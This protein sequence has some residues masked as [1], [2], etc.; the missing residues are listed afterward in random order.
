MTENCV[1]CHANTSNA[2]LFSEESILTGQGQN[3]S[4]EE[5]QPNDQE[6]VQE[7]SSANVKLNL[8]RDFRT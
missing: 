6:Y 5:V 3:E 2:Q 4:L 1:L 7:D 8:D